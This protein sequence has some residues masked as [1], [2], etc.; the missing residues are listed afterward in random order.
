MKLRVCIA[1]C[2]VCVCVQVGWPGVASSEHNARYRERTRQLR[3]QAVGLHAEEDTEEPESINHT[4]T[5]ITG[6]DTRMDTTYDTMRIQSLARHR[7]VAHNGSMINTATTIR[8]NRINRNAPISGG[9]VIASRKV[10]YINNVTLVQGMRTRSMRPSVEVGNVTNY[11]YA[12]TITNIVDGE[13]DISANDVRIGNIL[14]TGRVKR[15]RND[16]RLRGRVYTR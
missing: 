12:T 5:L 13:L 16:I 1:L 8:G 2:C 6:P 10:R 4:D 14:S 7:P 9:N 15:I 3:E 11:G